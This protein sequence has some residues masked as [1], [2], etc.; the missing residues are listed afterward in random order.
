MD[1][2]KQ[3][4]MALAT[5]GFLTSG[6]AQA[7]LFD[8]GGGLIYDDALNVTWLQNANYAASEL[9]D[10]R[11]DAIILEVG[12]VG[13]HALTRADFQGW[14]LPDPYDGNMNFWGATAWAQALTFGG[15]SDWRLPRFLRPDAGCTQ[16]VT[17]GFNCSGSEM[18]HL[19][20]ADLGGS[21]GSDKRGTQSVGDVTFFNIQANYISGT[22]VVGANAA[23]D[24]LFLN[25]WQSDTLLSFP[26]FAWAIRDGDVSQLAPIPEP[27]TYAM[28]LA[29]LGLLGLVAQ[30]RKAKL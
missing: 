20:Y 4:S 12:S 14:V 19:F 22:R 17:Q 3:V 27:E 10:A 11:R 30:G 8:R 6:M 7:T 9:N 26:N 5:A 18:G 25:G 13:G 16:S 28:M 1:G 2:F 29:G 23:G 21:A 24:F 15:Y